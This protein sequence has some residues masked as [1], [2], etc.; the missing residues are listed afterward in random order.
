MER[1]LRPGVL[2]GLAA[3]VGTFGVAAMMSAATAPTAR[4]DDFSNIINAID[5]DFTAG[6]AD[7]TAA[8]SDFGSISALH[9]FST[10]STTM[11]WLR[12]TTS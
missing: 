6:Q 10:E 7:F 3:T 4:A 5:G 8:V 1:A 12:R 9:T 2:I 11:Y